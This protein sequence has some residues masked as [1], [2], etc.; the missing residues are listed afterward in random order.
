M[1]KRGQGGTGLD[2]MLFYGGFEKAEVR[3]R[4]AG[5]FVGI[6][7]GRRP[8][9][10]LEFRVEVRLLPGGS[11]FSFKKQSKRNVRAGYGS[12]YCKSTLTDWLMNTIL[13]PNFFTRSTNLIFLPT[14]GSFSSESISLYLFST[15]SLQCTQR[16]SSQ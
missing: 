15:R 5:R 11:Y 13:L 7:L 16:R 14:F 4:L 8:Y 6:I 2:L 1:R 9:P 10:N 12:F 3:L